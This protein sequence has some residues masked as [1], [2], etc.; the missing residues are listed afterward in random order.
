M[1]FESTLADRLTS[2]VFL[3]IGTAMLYGGFVMDRLEIRQIHPASIPGLVPMMLGVALILCAV[4]LFFS[5]PKHHADLP[6]T[7]SEKAS[8]SDLLIAAGWS[9]IYALA[10]VGRLPFWLAT[11]IYIAA[12]AIYFGWPSQ[13]GATKRVQRIALS[14]VFAG[15]MTVAISTLFRYGFLVRLP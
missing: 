2:A 3:A 6:K 12:F 9:T 15:V 7:A 11:G 10:L 1:R 14:I 4:L 8:V 5:A 13:A